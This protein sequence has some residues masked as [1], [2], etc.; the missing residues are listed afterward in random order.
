MIIIYN[1]YQIQFYYLYLLFNLMNINKFIIYH[2]LN[3]PIHNRQNN[4]HLQH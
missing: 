4:L 3:I 1:R 2:I